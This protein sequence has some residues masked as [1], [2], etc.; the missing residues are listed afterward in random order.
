M[1]DF[2]DDKAVFL[3]ATAKIWEAAETPIVS[4]ASSLTMLLWRLD[5]L[6]DCDKKLGD[7]G[8]YK[9]QQQSSL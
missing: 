5:D 6:C 4:I 1:L 7:S 9:Q 3:E 8:L 2:D